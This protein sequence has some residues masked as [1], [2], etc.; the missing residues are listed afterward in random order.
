M[1]AASAAGGEHTR[2][3]PGGVLKSALDYKDVPYNIF[4]IFSGT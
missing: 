1:T 3:P 4:N 2:R